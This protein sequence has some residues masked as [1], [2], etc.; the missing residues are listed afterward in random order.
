M[1]SS[2]W[3]GHAPVVLLLRTGDRCQRGWRRASRC[4]E[5]PPPARPD[6]SRIRPRRGVKERDAA[7]DRRGGSPTEG[8]EVPAEAVAAIEKVLSISRCGAGATNYEDVLALAA[9]AGRSP[10]SAGGHCRRRARRVGQQGRP[11]W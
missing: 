5:E 8:R 9:M 2:K 10:P 7:T 11:A 4:S 1:R 6:S 3:S